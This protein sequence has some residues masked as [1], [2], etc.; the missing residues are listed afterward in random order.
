[1]DQQIA[2]VGIGAVLPG[3]PDLDTLWDNIAQ[4]R[5][6]AKPVAPD[7]WSMA[8]DDVLNPAGTHVDQVYTTNGCLVDA[9]D[10]DPAGLDLDPE[11]LDGLD[12]MFKFLLTAGRQAFSQ[13]VTDNLD[14]SRVGTIVGNLVL[15]TVKSSAISM[16]IIGRTLHEQMP[17]QFAPSGSTPVNRFTAGLPAGVLNKALGLGGGSYTLDAACASA[18][19]ALKLASEELCAG[20]ADAMLAGGLCRPSHMYLQMGFCQLGALSRTGRCSPLSTAADGMVVGEGAG[21]FCLKRLADAEA[22]GDHIHGVISDIGLSNDVK[23][24]IVAPTTEGQLRAMTQPYEK[25]GLKPWDLQVVECH[26]TATSIGDAVE[27]EALK[28]LWQ[29]APVDARCAVGSVKSNVGH[30]LT[31]AAAVSLI[32]VLLALKHKKLPPSANCD[33]MNPE[34]LTENCPFKVLSEPQDWEVANGVPRRAAVNAFGLGGTN[35]HAIIEEYVPRTRTKKAKPKSRKAPP[36]TDRIAIIGMDVHVGP[37]KGLRKFQERLF[38]G[39]AQTEPAADRSWYGVAESAWFAEAGLTPD[40]LKG[41]YINQVDTPIG[42]YRIPPIELQEMVPEQRVILDV[43]T[44]ALEDARYVAEDGIET[45]I[46]VGIGLAPI[47]SNLQLRWD[48]QDKVK[49][50]AAAKGVAIDDA[51]MA[52]WLQTLR[53]QAALPLTAN[54][55][56]GSLGNIFASRIA[57]EF[58][59]GGP[60][61]TI[62]CEE[63]SGIVALLAAVRALQSH[64]LKQAVVGAVDFTGDIRSLLTADAI[65]PYSRSGQSSPFHPD[66]DGPIAADGAAAVVL[67]RL[68]DAVADGDR[69]Y[70]V[71]DGAGHASGDGADLAVP[72]AAACSRAMAQAYE[73]AG[74]DPQSISLLATHASGY[75]A[76]D[77][78]ET[79]ATTDFFRDQPPTDCLVSSIA[80]HVGHTGVASGLISLIGASLSLY[81]EIVPGFGSLPEE[82]PDFVNC[83][84]VLPPAPQYWVR[85]REDGPRRAAVNALALDG[86][87]THVIL[88]GIESQ[89]N[90]ALASRERLQPAGV[91]DQAIFAIEADDQPGMLA[92][93]E[94]LHAALKEDPATDRVIEARARDWWKMTGNHPGKSMGMAIIA[95]DDDELTANIDEARELLHKETLPAD[96]RERIFFTHEPLAHTGKIALVC[97]GVGTQFYGMGR[98]VGVLWPEL[99]REQDAN[100][101]NLRD[102]IG[103]DAFWYG[104][105][106]VDEANIEKMLF[107]VIAHGI[108]MGRLVRRQGVSPDAS[109]G[110]SLGET[111]AMF[112]LDAWQDR[113]QMFATMRETRMFSRWLGGEFLAAKRKWGL[114]DDTHVDWYMGIVSKPPDQIIEAIGDNPRVY[115]LLINTDKRCVIGGNRPDVEAVVEKLGSRLFQIQGAASVHCEVADIVAEEFRSLNHMATT[116]PEG[117]D[118]YSSNTGKTFEMTADIASDHILDLALEPVDFPRVIRQAYEDG[119][120][121]FIEI[122]PNN[123]VSGIIKRIL[124]KQPHLARSVNIAGQ[125]THALLLRMLGSLISERVPVTFGGLYENAPVLA[126]FQSDSTDDRPILSLPTSGER[127]D[128]RMP[129]SAPATPPAYD[130]YADNVLLPS[131]SPLIAHAEAH[132]EAVLRAHESFLAYSRDTHEQ[133]SGVVQQQMT[134]IQQAAAGNVAVLDALP[135]TV[136][137][138]PVVAPPSA[139]PASSPTELQRK[140]R[141]KAPLPNASKP[142][143]D[144]E[145]CMELAIGS[146]ARVFGPQFADVDTYPVRVRLPDDPYMLVDRITVLEAEPLSMKTGR[147]V[148]EHDVLPDAWYLDS[149]RAA[150]CVAIESGQADLLLSGYLGADFENK[151]EA[152]YR[153]LDSEV[154]FH[155]GLPRPGEIMEFDITIH[156]FFRQGKTLLFRFQ[157]DASVDGQPFLTMRNGIAGFFSQAELDAGR[158]IVHGRL[159]EQPGAGTLPDNWQAL[160]PMVAESYDDDQIGALQN[161]DMTACFGDAFKALKVTDPVTI[162]SNILGILK[163]V[164][165]LEPSGGRYGLGRIEAEQDVT[166]DAWYLICH[167]CDD[168]VMPGTLMY[169]CCLHTMRIFMLR[170]GWVGERDATVFEPAVAPRP[171]RLKCRGQVL[172]T[173]KKATYRIDFKEFGYGPEPFAIADALMF[174]DGKPVVEIIDLTLRL[175]GTDEQTL[176]QLWKCTK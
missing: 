7:R 67:K 56:M 45:G 119:V 151:G 80:A 32:K 9:F 158:G 91:R 74:V 10:F 111:T 71:I 50:A 99:M 160:V 122:G 43:A 62:S 133:M 70:A 108:T 64:E 61:H 87:C 34:L 176:Q 130:D 4:C 38:G 134:L 127:F 173:T 116:A 121:I 53:D 33:E 8:P 162:P 138:V 14:R 26:A 11:W 110:Y 24:S 120:R 36:A 42:R 150:T 101:V 159:Q 152:M 104:N 174:A 136:V 63:C 22:A 16:D 23:G 83:G 37:W 96:P 2:I 154:R 145:M 141:S 170:M 5:D 44:S 168:P 149:G 161:G 112:A 93:L 59:F 131:A 29:D 109:L 125:D 124:G 172:P 85:N 97:P 129:S 6:V 49:A 100:A 73:E 25:L 113:D 146:I 105:G 94:R 103:A 41:Y 117:I 12:N 28:T 115:I 58:R 51:T 98:D 15:P 157:F 27:I 78:I 175:S 20:R 102:Q 54:R 118:F 92:Q 31:A 55:T 137:P 95:R 169:E 86:N 35:A 84:F 3:A 139:P 148:T 132:Q 60:S 13:A 18:L 88:T 39:D 19:Y 164:P 69:I 65:R 90:E 75:P 123:S 167:F 40:D 79:A 153:L 106:D 77:Q 156:R 144:R 171:T 57:R 89:P 17:G 135:D 166:P 1:M 66:A 142:L 52:K 48:L 72:S 47:V 81:Q 147:I 21:V 165:V 82:Q 163:R 155:N 107:G 140:A 128:V 126:E 76:E 30:L 46:F 143:Y 68:D 114:P